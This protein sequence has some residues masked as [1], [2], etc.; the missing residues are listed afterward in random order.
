MVDQNRVEGFARNVGGKLEDAVGAVTGD[1]ATQL[2]GKADQVAGQVQDAYGK[3][4]DDVRTFASD[5]P[6]HAMLAALSVGA[7]VGFLVGRR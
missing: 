5:R 1:A 3:V 4:V 6:L 2:R 7:V